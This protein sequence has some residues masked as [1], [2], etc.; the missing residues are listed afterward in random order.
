MAD[1]KALEKA[2]KEYSVITQF[3]DL[4]ANVK[5]LPTAFNKFD[6]DILK[7]GGLPKGRIIEVSGPEGSGK[8]SL[9]LRAAAVAQ[10]NEPDKFI[11]IADTE[12]T[13]TYD[14]LIA[15]GINP[16][17]CQFIQSNTQEEVFS[18]VLAWIR[19][20]LFSV[21]IIDSLANLMPQSLAKGDWYTMDKK[22]GEWTSSYAVGEF[23]RL[24]T[25]FAKQAVM[26]LAKT[27]TTLIAC[28]HLRAQIGGFSRPGMPPPTSTPGGYC[29]GYDTS[30]QLQTSKVCD[31]ISPTGEFEG[32]TTRV[33]VKRSKVPGGSG[34]STDDSSHLLFYAKNG[35]KKTE[36]FNTIDTA[37]RKNILVKAG[38]WYSLVDKSTGEIIKKFQG[39][40][41]LRN[42]YLNGD[43]EFAQLVKMVEEDAT[44]DVMSN[45]SGVIVVEGE[46]DFS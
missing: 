39:T 13:H 24:C 11:G 3:I 41:N 37:I 43:D 7:I 40:E 42:S 4:D 35:L 33:R 5:P 32:I 9:A 34:Q 19:T 30:L 28:N 31:L 26:P 44:E 45:D 38:A 46:D 17:G 21:V 12:G 25:N 1:I 10:K 20:G 22:T 29:F 23:S 27:E 36:V 6:T 16:E 8:S 18:K 15:N 14:W 2:L